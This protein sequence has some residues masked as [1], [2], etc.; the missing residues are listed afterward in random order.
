MCWFLPTNTHPQFAICP[1][2]IIKFKLEHRSN[3][4]ERLNHRQLDYISFV[5]VLVPPC[6]QMALLQF[7]YWLLSSIVPRLLDYLL[8]LNHLHSPVQ[9]LLHQLF[10]MLHMLR[11]LLTKGYTL[12]AYY[13]HYLQ[14]V[15]LGR[16]SSAD[17]YLVQ[18]VSI[19]LLIR[20]WAERTPAVVR[21]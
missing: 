17:R 3:L 13:F 12:I 11:L 18:Q 20:V 15:L 9:L 19:R 6:C 4:Y 1:I 7:V 10:L 21:Q 8:H 2:S 5:L 14:V 16:V